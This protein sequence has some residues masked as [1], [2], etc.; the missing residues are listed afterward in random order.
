MNINDFAPPIND[1]SQGLLEQIFFR[2][3]E[4]MVKYHDIESKSGIF[5]YQS[6]EIPVDI[7]TLAGQVRLKDFAWRVME[8]VAEAIDGHSEEHQQE[9]IADALHF[10]VEL[11]ILAGYGPEFFGRLEDIY[12]EVDRRQQE[13]TSKQWGNDEDELN[14]ARCVKNFVWALGNTMNRLKNKPWKQS[15]M[16]T[17]IPEFEKWLKMS[18]IQYVEVA[19]AF[20]IYTAEMLYDLYF[21]KSDV[22]K[23]RQRSGY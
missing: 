17:D 16:L 23:F 5:K 11:Y 20:H 1:G 10:L 6:E 21:R 7:Q 19:Q 22:N 8:E 3:F 2:Q 18:M 15:Q 12:N 14:I 9:E 13:F 4:L